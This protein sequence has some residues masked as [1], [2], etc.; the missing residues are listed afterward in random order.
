VSATSIDNIGG[1][2][3]LLSSA[4]AEFIDWF[5]PLT[6]IGRLSG[7][8]S[9]PL[10]TRIMGLVGE[11]TAYWIGAGNAVPM[12]NAIYEQ[13]NLPTRKVAALTV[14]TNEVLR[15]QG[16]KGEAMV[17][18]ALGRSMIR[19]RDAA[20][21]DPS[22][23]GVAGVQPPSITHNVTPIAS[24]GNPGT[25]VAA[26]VAAFE[27]DLSQAAF[28]TDP[29]TAAQMAL[30]RDAGGSFAFPEAGAAGGSIIGLPLIVSRSSPRSSAGG[31]LVLVDPSGIAIGEGVTEIR[32]SDVTSIEMRNDPASSAAI[33]LATTQV[34]MF[35]T[36]SS[37]VLGTSELNFEVIRPGAV[38]LVT[39][40]N[41][42][43]TA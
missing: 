27:G 25:D 26:L 11:P 19:A 21:I 34:S 37:A 38:A 9:V 10:A 6:I 42:S 18:N 29:T 30:A 1:G 31:I 22:M 43:T 40:A 8:V 41:Y 17:R 35:Q 4:L 7:L 23:A 28:V 20:F 39:G 15:Y 13:F 12:S 24:T 5:M 16:P 33:P 36:N 2:T 32:S 3:P 14:L